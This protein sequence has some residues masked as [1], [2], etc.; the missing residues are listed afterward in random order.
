M[1]DKIYTQE[2]AQAMAA[3]FK[4]PNVA[5]RARNL[6]T[7]ERALW[8]SPEIK[9]M[10]E[11]MKKFHKLDVRDAKKFPIMEAGFS[12]R[13]L[14]E[15]LALREAD[16]SSVFSQ[17]LVA[18]LQ[19]IVNNMYHID[20]S[21]TY[22]DWAH[23]VA[24]KKDTEPYAPNQGVSFPSQVGPSEVFPEVGAAALNIALKNYK[25]GTIYAL[26][27]EL[28]DDDQS[29]TFQAQ[30]GTL[31]QYMK[32]LGEVWS[33]GKLASVSG[34]VYSN[35]SIPTSETKPSG[36][37]EYPYTISTDTFIGGGYNAPATYTL[38]TKAALQTART[39]MMSQKNL[40]GLKMAI[41]VN[42]IIAGPA[43]EYDLAILM[44]SAYY[45]AGAAAAGVTGGA[46]AI[47]PLKGMANLTISPYVF[48]NDGTVNGDSLAWYYCDD[49]KP[50]FVFQIRE[51]ATVEQEAPNAG[52]SFNQDIV[53][54]KC[55]SRLNAD[56]I[57]PRFIWQGNDGSV[58][59]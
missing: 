49:T 36:E 22:E 42:R 1:E 25:Y 21:T 11:R 56:F 50:F 8:E 29:G 28:L 58:T 37:D 54:F 27:K 3:K 39:T 48:K 44:N 16:T 35:L 10:T 53:R 55:R 45:P 15:K 41:K 24:S 30:A 13:K 33:Y 2:E 31:G 17:F 38:P 12:F 6:K 18:G 26:E 5:K 32:L 20:D 52:Q 51:A 34:M 43:N 7:I 4:N 57:D 14:Q 47:N 23:V 40:Q 59:S 19:T 9:R 46:F